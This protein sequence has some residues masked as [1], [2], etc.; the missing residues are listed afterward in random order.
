MMSQLS[1]HTH[2]AGEALSQHDEVCLD[3]HMPAQ[4]LQELQLQLHLSVTNATDA[5]AWASH[6]AQ[7]AKPIC[8]LRH[9]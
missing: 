1:S 4:A 2:P 6:Q 8:S 7:A 3:N 5:Q 9:S